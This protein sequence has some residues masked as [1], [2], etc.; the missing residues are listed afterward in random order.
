ME[1]APIGYRDPQH[2]SLYKNFVQ[3]SRIEMDRVSPGIEG[4][5]R[6]PAIWVGERPEAE[7]V[8]KLNPA[9]HHG[10]VYR[11]K[12]E[13]GIET[14]VQR[15][16]LF[17][18]DFSTW[19][20]AP[21]ITIPGYTKANGNGPNRVPRFHTV[22]EEQAENYAVLRA[23]VMNAHQACL[24]TAER[25]VKQR[26]A[27]MGFPVTAWSTEK[28]ITFRTPA[29]Y[30]DDTEDMHA[31]A[32]NVLNNSFG[33]LRRNP[34]DRRL[35]ELEVI[36][37]SMTLLDQIL[38]NPEKQLMQLVESF[39]ISA[40]RV[41]EKRFGEA[42][43]LGWGVCEQLISVMWRDLISE[44]KANTS[45]RMKNQRIKK[46]TSRDFTASVILEF[47]EIMGK[48]DH[49]LFRR[50]NIVRQARNKWAHELIP[51]KEDQAGICIRAIEQLMEKIIGVHLTLQSGGRGGVPQW[52]VYML[53]QIKK[54]E[55]R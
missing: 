25:K 23:Q 24:T 34:F 12:L 7:K 16:G 39:Y 44:I 38:C 17:L 33:V 15:D 2:E 30:H 53:E 3:D 49:D 36:D 47:L 35:I 52:P 21:Q 32:R 54:E 29:S 5:F 26:S 8:L 18:F 20:I 28:A 41:R 51:P 55:G 43:M 10:I 19:S 45:D 50:L 22:A 1:K 13:C 46:L 14:R 37:Y 42:I 4:Y 31:L 9:V 40:C 48:V 6:I 11:K 27:A